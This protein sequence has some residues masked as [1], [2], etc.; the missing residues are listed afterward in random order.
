LRGTR[1]SDHAPFYNKRVPVAF[2]HT[3]LHEYYHT[4]R[5]TSEKINYDGLEKITKYGFDLLWTICNTTEKVEFDY[6]SFQ[7]MDYNHDHGQK[8]TLIEETP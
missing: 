5:D 8:D 1:G 2:L 3:G 6:G 4:P 7:E